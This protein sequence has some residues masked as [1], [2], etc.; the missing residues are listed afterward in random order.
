MVSKIHDEC[1]HIHG[2][3]RTIVSNSRG[4]SLKMVNMM[5][6][7]E[8]FVDHRVNLVRRLSNRGMKR[9][10]YDHFVNLKLKRSDV[11]HSAKRSNMFVI[12]RYLPPSEHSSYPIVIDGQTFRMASD[13]CGW[14][15]L[16]LRHGLRVRV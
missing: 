10:L 7:R 5:M 14:S 8:S 11:V 4:L 9:I 6:L 13:F 16:L 3:L 1:G 2:I 15:L 12:V